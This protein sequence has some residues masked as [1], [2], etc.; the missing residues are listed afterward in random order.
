MSHAAATPVV[1]AAAE[2]LT[3]GMLEELLPQVRTAGGL[4]RI[5]A[6]VDAPLIDSRPDAALLATPAVEIVRQ[7]IAAVARP[8]D[9]VLAPQPVAARLA[10]GGCLPLDGAVLP[11]ALHTAVGHLAAAAGW[12]TLEWI[13]ECRMGSGYADEARMF[14]AALDSQGLEPALTGYANS[15]PRVP[16]GS[17]TEQL[18][19]RC[20]GRRP[21]PGTAIGVWHEK[22]I[23]PALLSG[24]RRTVCR[25][26]FETDSLPA[27]WV[28]QLNGYDRVWVPTPFN[29]ETFA[30]AGVRPELMRVLPGTIDLERFTAQA[31]PR[32][33][34]GAEGFTFLSNFTFQE[35]KGWRELLRAYVLEFAGE[36]GVTLA[37][38]L[39]TGFVSAGEIHARVHE[40]VAG[41]GVPPARR[42]RI[43][44][45]HD[46]VSDTETP[47]FYTGA[48]AYVSPT[49]GEGWGRP[50]MEALA[51]GC[52]VIAS[53]WSG[54]LAFLDD[55]GAWLVDGEVVPVP[56]DIDNPTFRGQRWFA[57]DVDAL[58][59]AMR[60]VVSDPVAACVRAA[61][62]RPR[63]EAEFGLPAIAERLAE[64][65]LEA[66][67][68]R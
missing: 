10:S 6:P 37:L 60:A 1:V 63:L 45:T 66:L 61:S 36:E 35:R 42:P 64:L 46:E 22:P 17:G 65:T 41:L 54:Q 57:P 24:R 39:S 13:A 30:R 51:C 56:D 20:E 48:D 53:R 40:F 21:A 59:A 38:K 29:L 9:F 25:T 15:A 31:P 44:I 52:P 4:L 43:V 33:V 18:L 62:A 23:D 34:P 47:G 2:V 19:L 32:R 28:P 5:A 3:P 55:A 8:G 26:M 7:E 11:R 58:R 50:L 16:L 27:E 49:R 14:L 67:A 68:C 12:A